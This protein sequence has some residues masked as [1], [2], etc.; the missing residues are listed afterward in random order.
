MI[1]KY[2]LKIGNV[3]QVYA[4]FFRWGQ[5]SVDFTRVLKSYSIDIGAILQ[6]SKRQWGDIENGGR[7]GTRIVNIVQHWTWSKLCEYVNVLE[8]TILINCVPQSVHAVAYMIHNKVAQTQMRNDWLDL[9]ACDLL[10]RSYVRNKATCKLQWS[11]RI[12]GTCHSTAFPQPLMSY[13]VTL[14]CWK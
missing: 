1:S 11:A 13:V 3:A 14:T 5:V 8:C 6:L 4:L 10:P 12:L 7:H 2:W 9:G